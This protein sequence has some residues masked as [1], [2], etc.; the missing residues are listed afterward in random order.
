MTTTQ[1]FWDVVCRAGTITVE[2]GFCGRTHFVSD[3]DYDE[4]ELEGLREQA[5]ASPGKFVERH[6]CDYISCGE[7]DGVTAVYGCPCDKAARYERFIW[8]NRLMI[9]GYL[10]RRTAE[11]AR[12][13]SRD[14]EAV[15]G[16]EGAQV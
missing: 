6:E 4:G 3:G 5:K 11:E 9:A 8:E 16:I 7:L 10:K 12:K 15:A 1:T 2:C 13:A 14:A